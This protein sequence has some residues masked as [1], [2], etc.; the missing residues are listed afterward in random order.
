MNHKKSNEHH[1]NLMN[2]RIRVREEYL[3]QLNNNTNEH[4][5]R[6][7]RRRRSQGRGA[8][9]EGLRRLTASTASPHLEDEQDS[10]RGGL[11]LDMEEA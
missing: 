3:R 10:T 11:Q 4:F 1:T 6:T 9:A 2:H 5:H 7:I 8:T